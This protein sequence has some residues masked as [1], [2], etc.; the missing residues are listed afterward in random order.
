MNY[1][2]ATAPLPEADQLLPSDAAV[3]DSRFVLNYFRLSAD[4]RMIFGG[5]ERYRHTPPADIAAFVRPHMAAV[6]PSL[7]AV[8]IDY[9]WGGTVAVTMNR[10]PHVGRRG[11]VFFAHGFSGHGAMITTLTGEILAEALTGT[12][13]RF[14][15][16]AD[17]PSRPFPGGRF[18]AR[19]LATLGLIWYAMRDRL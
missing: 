6:F 18:L 16:L 12:A 19:P 10:L 13:G 15:V 2:V 8:P 1:N 5:G 9:A 14:D 4:R 7:S 11:R 17:L 3:A